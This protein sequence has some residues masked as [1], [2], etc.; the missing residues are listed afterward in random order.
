[1]CLCPFCQKM[2]LPRVE[3]ATEN[4]VNTSNSL[5]LFEVPNGF[6]KFTLTR[7]ADVLAG[8]GQS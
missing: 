2:R 1:M 7:L 4:P 8:L 5:A 3:F 6:R